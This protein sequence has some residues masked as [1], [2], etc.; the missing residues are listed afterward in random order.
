MLMTLSYVYN[1]H[2]LSNI[3]ALYSVDVSAYTSTWIIDLQK[4]WKLLDLM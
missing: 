1:M 2:C 4:Q 3:A